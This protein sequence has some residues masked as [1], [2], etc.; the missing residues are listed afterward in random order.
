YP[1]GYQ[2][3]ISVANVSLDD[4][5]YPSSS[6]GLSVDIASPG[7]NILSTATGGSYNG[8]GSGTSYASPIVAG[9]IALLK[10]YHPDWTNVELIAH[11]LLVSD[12]IDAMN[13]A[14]TN[15]LGNGRLNVFN[16]LNQPYIETSHGLEMALD[17]VLTPNDE[18][19]NNAIE[20]GELFSLNLR[21]RNY[22]HIE[23]ANIDLILSSTDPDIT[24]IHNSASGFIG[25]DDFLTLENCFQIQTSENIQSHFIPFEIAISSSSTILFGETLSFELLINSGGVFVWEGTENGNDLSGTFIKNYLLSE[26]LFVV[27]GN[28]FPA[29][30]TGFDAVFLSFGAIG[31][32]CVRL[33]QTSML[34]AIKD[35]IYE[36]GNIYIEGSDAIGFDLGYYLNDLTLHPLLGIETAVDGSTNSID[37]LIGQQNS[38]CENMQFSSSSQSN[39]E[40]IDIFTPNQNGQVAFVED[41]Y[42]NVAIQN[43]GSYGQ[44]TFCFS[45]V[46]SDLTDGVSPNTREDLLDNILDFFERPVQLSTPNNVIVEVDNNE[47][48]ISWEA[49]EWANQYKVY[50]SEFPDS[51]FT[52]DNSGNFLGNSWIA[53][54][55]DNKRFYKITAE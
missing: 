42:G 32:N 37:G 12:N 11:T 15:K 47:V 17:Q 8:G 38:I 28:E 16:M 10:S 39:N 40:W 26:D 48:T 7:A 20:A 50:S 5:K 18:N 19:S 55:T 45:Y 33:S 53:P 25:N 3:V 41:N 30:F 27:Y 6:Y 24:I 31:S 35:Y 13:P 44:K 22:S 43:E 4:S 49:V 1:A 29:S 9:G 2:N 52:I 34:D 54:A 23:S 36:G 46:L 21:F 14:Y 51:D